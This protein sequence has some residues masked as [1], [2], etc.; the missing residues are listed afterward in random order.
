MTCH[1]V[2]TQQVGL[3]NL[4]LYIFDRA[5]LHRFNFNPSRAN[6]ALA[7]AGKNI[8]VFSQWRHKGTCMQGDHHFRPGLLKAFYDTDTGGGVCG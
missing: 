2:R 3:F 4:H 5:P 8:T 6:F 7:I 1:Q